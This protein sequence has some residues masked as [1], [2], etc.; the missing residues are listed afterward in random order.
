[1]KKVKKKK[2]MHKHKAKPH[3]KKAAQPKMTLADLLPPDAERKPQSG[4]TPLAPPADPARA[5]KLRLLE[6]LLFAAQTPLDEKEIRRRLPG[7]DVPGLIAE[8]EAHYRDRGVQIVRVAGGWTLRTAP[9]LGPRLKLVQKVPRR[10]SRAAIETLAIVAYH[11]SV[12]RAEIEDIRGV[13]VSAGTLDLLMEIGWIAPKGRRE[14]VGRPVTWGTTDAFLL[15]FN[16]GS[17]GDLPGIEELRSAG[18][19][20]PRP[21]LALTETGE[22]PPPDTVPESLPDSGTTEAEA[23]AEAAAHELGRENA[24]SAGG[25]E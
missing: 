13:M 24:E 14:T 23:E 4:P 25:G 3:R 1:M 22:L 20:G 8:L 17:I 5:D 18:L 7:A 12:T 16:L 9:E 11:Q 19:I 10:L 21:D 15:H 2:T 6:A